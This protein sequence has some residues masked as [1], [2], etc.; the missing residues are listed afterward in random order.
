MWWA[1]GAVEAWWASLW[2]RKEWDTSE[3]L[4]PHTPAKCQYW[5]IQNYRNWQ[6]LMK[7]LTVIPSSK[8]CLQTMSSSKAKTTC[9]PQWLP[10]HR[11]SMTVDRFN[12]T[13][14][15]HSLPGTWQVVPGLFW[16]SQVI[17]NSLLCKTAR[18]FVDNP[19]TFCIGKILFQIIL[20]FL[21]FLINV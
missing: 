7:C 6:S 19:H 1:T 17:G 9:F 11:C 18:N 5:K 3:R 13:A 20:P 21:C 15:Q 12:Q 2:G 10:H 14:S 16:L 4:S 8:W